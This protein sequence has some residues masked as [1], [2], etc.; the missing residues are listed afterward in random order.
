MMPFGALHPQE[1]VL[2]MATFVVA[3]KFLLYV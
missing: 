2:Q 1:A 3:G